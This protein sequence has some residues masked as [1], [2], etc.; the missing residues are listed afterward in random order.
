DSAAGLTLGPLTGGGTA[1]ASRTV[2]VAGNAIHA[3]SCTATDGASNTGAGPG[4]TNTATI[5]ID[6]VKPMIS[7]AATS[8]AN[9]AGW[10][11]NV[12]TVKIDKTAPTIVATATTSPNANGWYNHDVTVHFDCN[13]ALSGVASG[14]CASDQVL[15]SEGAAVASTAKTVSDAAGNVSAPSNV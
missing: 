2:S 12:V 11:N 7:A 1:S 5:K 10:Y 3:I 14:A 8:D 13:D 4:S 6:T 15:S 9:A